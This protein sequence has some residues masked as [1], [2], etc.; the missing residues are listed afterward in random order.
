MG[1]SACGVGCRL[2]TGVCA[3]VS[4]P[5]RLCTW[6]NKLSALVL[7]VNGASAATLFGTA[8]IGSIPSEGGLTVVGAGL[9]L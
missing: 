2:A 5:G 3:G 8:L 7:G 9:V 4:V 1:S 6:R